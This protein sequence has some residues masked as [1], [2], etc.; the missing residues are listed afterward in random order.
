[1]HNESLADRE[2]EPVVKE[3]RIRKYGPA[4]FW[5][6]VILMPVANLGAAYL[7]Y[8]D[9]KMQL[10]LAQLKELAETAAQQ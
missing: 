4:M 7:G 2:P 10:E 9:T 1:M 5:A 3:S 6:G 8:K